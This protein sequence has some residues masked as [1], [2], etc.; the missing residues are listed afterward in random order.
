MIE[1]TE[2]AAIAATLS[3]Q[4]LINRVHAVAGADAGDPLNNMQDSVHLRLQFDL[5]IEYTHNTVFAFN[6]IGMCSYVKT[7]FSDAPSSARRA[8]CVAVA[9][10]WTPAL[11]NKR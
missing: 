4:E 8:A 1:Q 2:R 7:R 3:D 6:D 9:S 10:M 5:T 11:D